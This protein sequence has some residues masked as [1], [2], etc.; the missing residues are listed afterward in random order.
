MPVATFRVMPGGRLPVVRA[1]PTP[2]PKPPTC[3]PATPLSP[4]YTV[5]VAVF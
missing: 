4:A 2:T 1:V 5:V 3:K